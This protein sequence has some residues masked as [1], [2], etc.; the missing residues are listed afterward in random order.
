[1]RLLKSLLAILVLVVAVHT[2]WQVVPPVYDN[3][4]FEDAI[5]EEAMAASYNPKSSEQDIAENVMRKAADLNVPLD[6]EQ[7]Q[8]QREGTQISISA[9][10]SVHIDVPLYPFDLTFN[11][12]TKDSA[13]PGASP[14]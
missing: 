3:Y 10:Y 1:M 7:L 8:V 5:R 2:L 9:D 14:R 11:P 4:Q 6:R 13:M 12:S